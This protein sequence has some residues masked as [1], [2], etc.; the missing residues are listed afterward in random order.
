[1]SSIL[2]VFIVSI[3]INVRAWSL[4]LSVSICLFEDR[5]LRFFLSFDFYFCFVLLTIKEI[6]T[7]PLS[8]FCIPVTINLI[9]S[10]KKFVFIKSYSNTNT[11]THRHRTRSVFTINKRKFDQKVIKFHFRRNCVVYE[12][13]SNLI[14]QKDLKFLF[15]CL[16]FLSII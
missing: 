15:Y 5:Q 4:T 2:F 7:I 9:R 12:N 11:N 1:M 3:F 14:R 6:W 16:Q 8:S 13:E 10:K